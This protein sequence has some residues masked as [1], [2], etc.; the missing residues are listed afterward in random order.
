MR[1]AAFREAVL[2][3]EASY[4]KDFQERWLLQAAESLPEAKEYA[5][6]RFADVLEPRKGQAEPVVKKVT[7]VVKK[8]TA[9]GP[10]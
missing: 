5:N 4:F 6:K 1:S 7:V 2:H 9:R 10:K 3:A 8:Y